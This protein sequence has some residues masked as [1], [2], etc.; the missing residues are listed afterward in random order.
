[1]KKNVLMV[2]VV[3]FLMFTLFGITY[4]WQGRM[5]GM[6]DPVG[7]IP[8][9]SDFLIN[10][11]R[12][13]DGNGVTLFSHYGFA[14]RGE[15]NSWDADLSG[16]LIDVLL[17]GQGDL[18]YD[19]EKDGDVWWN[20]VLL[21]ASFSLG[22]GKMGIFFEYE[23]EYGDY[24]GHEV[25][26]GSLTGL[27]S[28]TIDLENDVS[29]DMS[30]FALRFVYGIP[31]GQVFNLGT[32]VKIAYRDEEVKWNSRLDNFGITP[33]IPELLGISLDSSNFL[34][35]G[36]MRYLLPHDSDYWDLSF[37]L[38]LNW[39]VGGVECDLTPRGGFIFAGDNEW[40][41]DL[42]GDINLDLGGP[43]IVSLSNDFDMEGD[44]DGW[45]LG[46]DFWLR[47]PVTADTS[48]PL[49][50]RFDYQKKERDGSG[51][52]DFGLFA[53]P[54][55]GPTSTIISGPMEWDYNSEETLLTITAGG[56][57]DI[58]VSDKTKI[59]IGLFYNYI[60]SETDLEMEFGPD[61][62]PIAL[63]TETGGYPETSEHQVKLQFAGE[64]KVSSCLTMR[65]GLTTFYGWVSEEYDFDG[66]LSLGP[67]T[68]SSLLNNSISLDGNRWGIEASVGATWTCE[69]IAVEPFIKGG[70][71]RVS[72]DGD[73]DWSALGIDLLSFDV[74]KEKDEWFIGG[75]FSLLFNM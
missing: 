50:F 5:D 2:M 22:T 45:N 52:G 69:N 54:D 71:Q 57:F 26:D 51:S 29:T 6:G 53:T 70:Y 60:N 55:G 37:K 65:G 24:D 19:L 38:G 23:G 61:G 10:P 49:V 17:S 64:H 34:A 4:A 13:A 27:G 56:G 30:D 16:G 33:A 25:L 18:S 63:V 58:G 59:A 74:E 31:L 3:V 46:L 75:G 68:A 35:T 47:F 12:I 1:M 41:S 15:D 11:A 40:E 8:D 36:L 43:G 72:L 66:G 48:M 39:K 73:E 44:V 9:E 14:Y 42:D 28:A 32:E 62:P 20:E 21:G 67:L 7:L